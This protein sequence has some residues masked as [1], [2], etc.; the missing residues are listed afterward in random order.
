MALI[1]C[2]ECGGKLSDQAKVCVH[3]GYP[4]AEINERRVLRLEALKTVGE[5]VTFGA[6]HQAADGIDRTPIEW[7][8][9]DYD[10]P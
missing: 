1:Q 2:P 7:L 8:V 9:L 4:L 10:E 3:C 5:S 6:Y